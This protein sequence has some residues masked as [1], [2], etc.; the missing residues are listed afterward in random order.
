M[1]ISAHNTTLRG[2]VTR[3]RPTFKK[4]RRRQ[5]FLSKTNI[6]KTKS[7]FL[8]AMAF[9]L[10][11]IFALADLTPA[12]I[13]NGK[14]ATALVRVKILKDQRARVALPK[15]QSLAN[16]TAF[17]IEASG[18]FV[19]CKHVIDDA[20]DDKV[21][22]VLNTNEENQRI[23]EA[24]IMRTDK[25][26][27][28]AVLKVDGGGPY[29]ALPLGKVDRL[30][31]TAR[32]IAFGYPFGEALALDK[33]T[34][35]S[36]SVSPGA[37]TSLRKKNGKL[38]QIQLD[39]SLNPGNSGGPVLDS[40][41]RVVGI[42]NAGIKGAAVNFAIPVTHL[43]A[44]LSEPDVEFIAPALDDKS[45]N[46]PA[47]FKANVLMVPGVATDY[48]A[49]DYHA[50]LTLTVDGVQRKIPMK[51]G[52]DGFSA[53]EVPAPPQKGPQY[54]S[55]SANYGK[56]SVSGKIADRSFT[57]AGKPYQL[58]KV[59]HLGSDP[60]PSIVLEDGTTVE[61]IISGLSSVAIIMDETQATFD[62]TKAT[63]VTLHPIAAS[64]AVEYQ[65]ELTKNG[66]L[67]RKA[68]G[69]I[70]ILKTASASGSTPA[71][72]NNK[73]A[74]ARAGAQQTEIKLPSDISD[75]AVGGGGRYLILC[76]RKLRQLAIFDANSAKI[77]KYLPMDS[78]DTLF[79]AGAEKLVM[80]SA[81][82]STISRYSLKTFEREATAPIPVKGTIKTV[83]MGANSRGPLLVLASSP[84]QQ[85]V[86]LISKQLTT[87]DACSLV[88]LNSLAV[89]NTLSD[90]RTIPQAIADPMQIRVSADGTV[91][92][93]WFAGRGSRMQRTIILNGNEP[94]NYF[95]PESASWLIPSPDGRIIYSSSG[96]YTVEA[97]MIGERDSYVPNTL[98]IP[99]PNGNYYLGIDRTGNISAYLARESRAIAS[100]PKLGDIGTEEFLL[101]NERVTI[102][103]DKRFHFV[104]DA[105][106]VIG[107]P[108]TNDRLILQQFDLL[109]ALKDAAIDYLFVTSSPIT[110][111]AK[112]SNYIDQIQVES[113]RG[114]VAFSLES[115]PSGMSITPSGKLTWTA[116]SAES[117][118][119]VIVRI[120]DASGKEIF[121]TFTISV[122]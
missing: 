100:L 69:I 23:V 22:L 61:G 112:N 60:K 102:T 93:I 38:E 58:S 120:T 45:M 104:P 95:F 83:A 82:Q 39:A 27:D 117:E 33:D 81:S 99:A 110:S 89:K 14:K 63:S 54:I 46:K 42:A 111:A 71:D 103:P 30:E 35:P 66:K 74:S 101:A 80:V 73:S 64:D 20:A 48:R 50:E 36:I 4:M 2:F 97:K 85:P 51:R 26:N 10:A 94:T 76:L 115:G 68:T 32:L 44:F 9:G 40:G 62:L 87:K 18:W 88:D 90:A 70:P 55:L 49:A 122:R 37:I 119:T 109:K 77:V 118:A 107:I 65:L 56:N 25:D 11:V 57:V 105:R 21:S 29:V 72:A 7:I 78:D 41:G 5:K 114:D 106:L 116:G 113:K 52:I 24:K 1:I 92:S 75:V 3:F 19:T 34:Y 59:K 79:A 53:E 16:G 108:T 98:R 13:E 84:L 91:F 86:N 96:L 17:C 15:K 31:E 28:L 6:H 43:Y 47:L 8:L 12:Q 121:H 67:V